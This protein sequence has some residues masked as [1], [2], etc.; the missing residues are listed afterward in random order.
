M[1]YV[2]QGASCRSKSLSSYVPSP[3]C[4]SCSRLGRA[5]SYQGQKSLRLDSLSHRL[6]IIFQ[7][8][9]DTV[10]MSANSRTISPQARQA[11][12]ETRRR[13]FAEQAPRDALGIFVVR[14]VGPTQPFG[15]E[16]RKFGSFIVSRS[17]KGFATQLEAKT[18]GEK[19]LIALTSA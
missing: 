8:S 17:D 6:M 4:L 9:E 3:S 13:R 15:W 19:A 2:H 18:A 1:V 10:G 12:A 11:A 7:D 5:E 14:I 16:I